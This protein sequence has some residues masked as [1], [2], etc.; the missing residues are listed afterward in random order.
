MT[1]LFADVLARLEGIEGWL[2]DEQARV[3]WDAAQRVGPGGTIVE[4]GSFRGRSTVVLATAAAPGTQ[5]VAVDPHAGNDRGPHEFTGYEREAAE[6]HEA[7]HRNLEAAGVTER[8]RHVRQ[9]SD[10][11]HGE[12][13]GDVDLLYIDGAHRFGPAA[14]DIRR[15]GE[16]VGPGGTMA[17]HDSFSSV[18]VTLAIV[19]RLLLHDHFR[20]LGRV[21]SLT[22]Y[23]R[24]VAAVSPV[25]RLANAAHQCLSL[26]WFVR[27]LLIKAL[28]VARLGSLTILLGH[29]QPTWPY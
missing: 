4:I 28:I 1:T 25:G 20:Y 13:D 24:T 26:P 9:A 14:E 17:I 3:L 12:V 19:S 15:W 2:S 6:D 21:G 29:R 16:R 8:V 27:N 11:A 10:E 23:R 22:T 7:F 5:I 18:G